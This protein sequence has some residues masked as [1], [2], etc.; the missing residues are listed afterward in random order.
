M[1]QV[2][3]VAE[4]VTH[5]RVDWTRSLAANGTGEAA[6]RTGIVTCHHH[7]IQSAQSI[8]FQIASSFFFT[9]KLNLKLTCRGVE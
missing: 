7:S 4:K 8:Q 9:K 5:L 2:G 1:I 6:K 3:K